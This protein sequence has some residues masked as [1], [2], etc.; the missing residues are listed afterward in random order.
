[1]RSFV[2]CTQEVRQHVTEIWQRT[3]N[4][5]AFATALFESGYGLARGD[6]RDFVVIDCRGGIHSLTRCVD[7]A[8]AREVRARK[9]RNW[10]DSARGNDDHGHRRARGTKGSR[11]KQKVNDYSKQGVCHVP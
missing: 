6:R 1:M 10:I 5:R 7:G 8:N 3:D 2:S 11:Q 4:G 9:V